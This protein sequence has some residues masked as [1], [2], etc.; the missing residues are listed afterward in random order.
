MK[1]VNQSH[2]IIDRNSMTPTKLIELGARTCYASTDKIK[3]GSDKA[4]LKSIIGKGHF[5]VLEHSVAAFSV[6]RPVYDHFQTE[7]FINCTGSMS[8]YRFVVSGN[9]R[10]W[11]EIIEKHNY[12]MTNIDNIHAMFNEP[13]FIADCFSV[14]ISGNIYAK[15]LSESDMTDEEKEIHAY[16]S[17]M[18]ITGRDVSHEIVRH[19]NDIAISQESQR[20]VKEGDSISFIE[21]VNCRNWSER[22]YEI[23]EMSGYVAEAH[24]FEMVKEGATPED[25]RKVLTSSTRTKLMVSASISEWK[26]IFNLRTSKG[27]YPEI[28]A[29]TSG[30]EQDFKKRWP[31]LFVVCIQPISNKQPCGSYF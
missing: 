26:H 2:E 12:D 6:S 14:F 28:R 18:L 31:E 8:E 25:A 13:R 1:I 16:R 27:A 30:M 24:Y 21:P 23:W 15:V 17:I 19:R 29:L 11:L 3:P 20:Y 4:I 7:K 22:R 10:A 9:M 5:S